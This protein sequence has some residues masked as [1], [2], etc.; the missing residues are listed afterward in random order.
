M[1]ILFIGHGN[2]MN[3][4]YNNPFT[5]TPRFQKGESLKNLTL[6]LFWLSLLTGFQMEHAYLFLQNP[7]TIS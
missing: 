4:I 1:P 3:A 5:Q 7:P 6:L 2:P